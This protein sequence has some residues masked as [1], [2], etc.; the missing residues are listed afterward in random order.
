MTKTVSPA[1]EQATAADTLKKDLYCWEPNPKTGT[2]EVHHYKPGDP[3]PAHLTDD[4]R[5]R[6]AEQGVL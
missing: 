1:D 6:L 3:V 2:P 4:Q 5:K